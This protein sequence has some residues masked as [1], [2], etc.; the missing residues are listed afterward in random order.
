MIIKFNFMSSLVPYRTTLKNSFLINWIIFCIFEEFK[1]YLK[2]SILSPHLISSENYYHFH[3]DQQSEGNINW[4]THPFDYWGKSSKTKKFTW[5]TRH[6]ILLA[7]SN[8]SLS[9]P[10]LIST[11]FYFF[12]GARLFACYFFKAQE[13]NGDFFRWIELQI[14]FS[15]IFI[16]SPRNALF[17]W[18]I[19]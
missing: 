10:R 6:K 8:T 13:N 11:N 9:D 12:R 17:D 1:I 5:K 16:F 7:L 4:K 15:L 14:I 19:N 18:E 3:F 2:L